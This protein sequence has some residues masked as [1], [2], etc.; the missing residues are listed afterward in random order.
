MEEKKE[1]EITPPS[2]KKVRGRPITKANAKQY[3]LSAARAKKQR[4]QA[5]M[6]MLN[7]MVTQLNLGDELVKAVKTQDD[8]ALS[9]IE[10]ALR[11]T[12]LH[13]DQGPEAVQNVKVDAKSETKNTS[14]QMVK[15]VLDAPPA[16]QG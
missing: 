6:E 7:A 11:I 3:Q 9:C 1:P 15:F 5:R 4:K 12:G 16:P 8:K 14:T 13:F 2:A 10:K